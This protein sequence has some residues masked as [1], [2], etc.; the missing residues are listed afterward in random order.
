M[1]RA[2]HALFTASGFRPPN[3][4]R[5]SGC[6]FI[7]SR[8]VLRHG[9]AT[10]TNTR[11]SVAHEDHDAEAR[12]RATQ[13][14]RDPAVEFNGL[15][16]RTCARGFAASAQKSMRCGDT[17]DRAVGRFEFGCGGRSAALSRRRSA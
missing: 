11:R 10:K 15:S 17:P 1:V 12:R 5:G 14:L 4:A 8:E 6:D 9:R 3:E 7:R 2:S 16:A 13:S